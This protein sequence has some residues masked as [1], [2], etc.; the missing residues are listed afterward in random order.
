MGNGWVVF[1]EPE[2]GKVVVGIDPSVGGKCPGDLALVYGHNNIPT[3]SRVQTAG[4][5]VSAS[6]SAPFDVGT[7][8]VDV[9]Y[10]QYYSADS[11][12][13]ASGA[14]IDDS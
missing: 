5:S 6:Y 4:G 2:D 3:C 8:T 1:E 11:F 14:D 10:S 9:S 7:V 13:S 12:S